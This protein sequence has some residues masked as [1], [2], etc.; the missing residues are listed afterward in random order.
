MH[1]IVRHALA[2]LGLFILVAPSLSAAQS[3]QRIALVIGNAAYQQGALPTTAN[4][5]GLVAQTLQAAGFDV[6]GARDLDGDTLRHTLRDFIQKA[7]ASGPDTVAMIYLGGYALQMSGENFFVPVDAILLRDT[8]L[9]VE[10]LR[11]SD[12]IRQLGTLPLRAGIFILDGAHAPPFT[13]SG[14]PLAG[15]L[16]LVEPDPNILVAFNAAPGTIGPNE[17]GPYGAYAEALAEMIRQGGLSLPELFNRVR[18]RVNE[19]TKGTEVPWNAQHI[20]TDFVFFE[21]GPDAPQAAR[22]AEVAEME[23]RPIRDF[24][25]GDAYIAALDRDTLQAYEEFLAA[26]PDDRLAKRVRAIVAARREAITWRRSC[27][28][29]TPNAYWSYLRRYP[30]GPHA[31]DARR[32]LPALA[33]DLEPPQVFEVMNYDVPPPPPEEIV[34]VERP[35]IEFDDPAY[36][37]ASPPPPPVFFL[38]PTEPEFIVLPPPPPPTALFVLPTPVFVAMPTYVHPPAYVAPPPNNIIFANIHN[39][40]VINN[41]INKTVVNNAATAGTRNAVSSAPGRAT[42]GAAPSVADP[43]VGPTLP[44]SVARK[45]P[46]IQPQGSKGPP[47]PAMGQTPLIPAPAPQAN[48]PGNQQPGLPS[49]KLRP[50]P[51]ASDQ[52][53]P[54]PNFAP[55]T[56][57][58]TQANRPGMVTAIPGQASPAGSAHPSGPPATVVPSAAPQGAQPGVP[59][60]AQPASS[61]AAPP[62]ATV[63]SPGPRPAT[64][65]TPPSRSPQIVNRPPPQSVTPP[66]SPPIVNR[67]PP[68]AVPNR[69]PAPRPVGNQFSPLP[70][71]SGPPAAV[72]PGT[73]PHGKQPQLGVPAAALPAA[74]GVLPP[75]PT[76]RPPGPQPLMKN[77]P[78]PPGAKQT[79]PQSVTPPAPLPA[80][81]QSPSPSTLANRPRSVPPV[82]NRPPSPPVASRP[83]PPPPVVNRQSPAP[84]VVTR[85]P[86][87]PPSAAMN[88]PPAPPPTAAARPTPQAAKKCVVQNGKQICG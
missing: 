56:T 48:L 85:L 38:P 31:W 50:L 5:A 18:L 15:G 42:G 65:N 32:R 41:A 84:A 24:D 80:V 74:P 52:P 58:P 12:Y 47:G 73:A 44:P 59:A 81:H 14:P 54:K 27:R 6:V 67:S 61:D 30:N 75:G 39:T 82:V 10:A 79:S 62:T 71:A 16:A 17:P 25:A 8:D 45:A 72:A 1:Q 37:F 7:A 3:E 88:R 57:T 28:A 83:A 33:A 49:N 46:P 13:P 21:R 60:A 19:I 20:Q 29:D 76:V 69:P 11:V 64:T 87:P 78:S 53:L 68:P 36:A 43:T 55:A 9:P 4:D 77:L 23:T 2:L 34:Y 66:S 22:P 51:G 40:T 26:F 70:N 35:V 63:H 86:P